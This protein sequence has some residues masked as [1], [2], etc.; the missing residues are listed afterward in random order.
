[1]GTPFYPKKVV[2]NHLS[3]FLCLYQGLKLARESAGESSFHLPGKHLRV[4]IN[5]R[6]C[7]VQLR[8]RSSIHSTNTGASEI[9]R[10]TGKDT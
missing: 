8:P 2:N 5:F 4:N 7:R 3:L 1:M 9:Q 6:P 10:K